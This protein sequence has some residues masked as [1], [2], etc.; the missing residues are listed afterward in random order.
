MGNTDAFLAKLGILLDIF[1]IGYFLMFRYKEKIIAYYFFHGV[2]G[3]FGS[4]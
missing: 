3:M 1:I 2:F 4:M